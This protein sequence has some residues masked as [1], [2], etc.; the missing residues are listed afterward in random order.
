MVLEHLI[1]KIGSPELINLLTDHLS[2]SELQTLLLYVFQ[3]RTDRLKPNQIL[4]SYQK[5]R[6]VH[7][8]SVS[9]SFFNKID[10][11]AYKVAS[12]FEPL[13][14]S[15]LAPLGACSVLGPV[16]Q[17]KVVSTARNNEILSDCTNIMALECASRR[18]QNKDRATNIHLCTSHRLVRAQ[19]LLSAHH[20]AHFRVFTL[21]SAGKDTGHFKFEI[22]ALITQLRFYLEFLQVLGQEGFHFEKITIKL[23]PLAKNISE[24]NVVTQIF[25]PLKVLFPAV[26]Y[27][28]FPERTSGRGYYR[29]LCFKVSAVNKE[30]Q[31]FDLA[32]GGFTDW[33][34]QLM[35]DKKERNLISGIGTELICKC[36]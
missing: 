34:Q 6:F 1:K 10:Q 13:E 32:D 25:E 18:K 15:P 23:T 20:T 36:F 28:I 16:S 33:T 11:L 21:C 4:Q 24:S 29:I 9:A 19:S 14:L 7:P 12:N 2:G 27:S 26:T 8:S 3:Q 31:V 5:N 17:N 30:G 22:I 35:S